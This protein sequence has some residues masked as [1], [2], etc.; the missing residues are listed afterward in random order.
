MDN[1]VEILL[2]SQKNVNSVNTDTYGKVEL[3]SNVSEITEF[4]VNDVVNS[5]E[6]FDAEREANPVYR[7]Y[8]RIEY[9]SLLNGLKNNYSVLEDFFNPQY[10]GNSKNILNSF[11]FYLVAPSSGS[12]VTYTNITNTN[13]Y[14]RNFKVIAGRDDFEIYPAGFTNNVYGEQVYGFSFKSDFDIANLYDYFGFPMTELFLYAQYKPA[15]SPVEQMSYTTWSTSTGLPSK[16]TLYK[17]DLVVDDQVETNS[18]V[19]I[20]D[21]IEWLPDEFLQTQV[22]TQQFYIRTQYNDSG[23]KWLEWSYNPFIP[24]RLRYFDDALSAANTGDTS[25]EIVDSIP[26]Y[27]TKIDDDGN[28]VWREILPQGYVEPLT[29]VGVDYPFSNKRRYLFS[30]IIFDVIPN[31]SENTTLKHP[32][33]LLVFNEISYVKNA[34]NLDITPLTELDNIGKPCQ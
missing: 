3:T 18:L 9:M 13:K 5:T 1:N 12:G 20:N 8:G 21:I 24:F 11:D 4:T 26:E 14:K 19:D 30:P 23:V 15:L 7:I 33:T 31:L 27:A 34:T 16:V 22:E 10:S 25:Y 28:Y 32:N 6:V 17:K 2:G 29:G